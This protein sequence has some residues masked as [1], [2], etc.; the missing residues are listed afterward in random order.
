MGIADRKVG[1]YIRTFNNHTWVFGATDR[2][3]VF[4]P[5]LQNKQVS[6][7][8][9]LPAEIFEKLINCSISL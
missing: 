9:F 6:E 3:K 7:L 2:Q 1:T 5:S 8:Q 4:L